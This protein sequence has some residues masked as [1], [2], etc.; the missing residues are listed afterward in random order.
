MI[1]V[2]FIFKQSQKVYYV[3]VSFTKMIFLFVNMIAAVIFINFVQEHELSFL[4]V[5]LAWLYLMVIVAISRIDKDFRR[6]A[7]KEILN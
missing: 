6:K 4:Y 5:L 1:A 2:V 7:S 3:P